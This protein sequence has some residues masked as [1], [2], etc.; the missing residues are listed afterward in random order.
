MYPVFV[1]GKTLLEEKEQTYSSPQIDSKNK[2]GVNELVY[3]LEFSKQ[4]HVEQI[5]HCMNTE[6]V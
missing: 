5:C 4:T 2:D 3:L 1:F 6:S